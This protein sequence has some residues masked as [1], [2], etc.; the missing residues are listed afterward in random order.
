MAR[1]ENVVA[2]DC[3]MV[4]IGMLGMRDALARCSIVNYYGTVIY[5]KFVKPEEPII[6]YRTRVSGVRPFDLEGAIPFETAREEILKILKGKLVVGHSLKNDFSVLKESMG[7]YEVYDTSTDLVLRRLGGLEGCRRV[8][9]R[10]LCE[11]ILKKRIQNS[12]H[13]HCSV[14]D[15]RAALELYK[16]SQAKGRI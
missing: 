3:E 10:V 7:R 8:S 15:A 4:G 2:L 5:D 1:S 6:D 12:T 9:L 14:E 11:K 16:V 13:G